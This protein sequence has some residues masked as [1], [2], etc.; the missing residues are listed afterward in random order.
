MNNIENY[1]LGDYFK[2]QIESINM[3]KDGL[4]PAKV[5]AVHKEMYIIIYD[6]IEK[7]ARLKGSTFYNDEYSVYPTVGDFVLVK[8]NPY[9][10]DIIHHVLDRK[11]K[12]SRYD[13]HYDKEQI[14]AA[15]F[16]RVFIVSSL[17]YDFN[18]KRIERYLAIAWESGASPAIILTKSDLVDDIRE[19]NTKIEEVAIGVPIFYISSLTGE[20]IDELKN[21]LKPKETIVFLGS[22]GVGKS[23]L[24]NALTG[25]EVMKVNDIREDD[26]KGR[27]TTTHRQLIMLSN[28]TMV[29]DTPGMREIALW[30][31]EDG[32]SNTFSD[33]EELAS[34]CK[35]NDCTHKK[36]PG[37]AIKLALLK[38]QLSKDRWNNYLKLQ[39]E[40][41]FTAKKERINLM[42]K[43]KSK[44]K[45]KA[46]LQNE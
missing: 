28:G 9:G 7:R 26:S 17:N 13:S 37:C 19:Y 15:N 23:S 35:F 16:D 41:K 18:I 46:K 30:N 2:G 10:E 11:S 21:Y 12:F 31:V 42:K 40:V 38:N 24:V 5:A 44:G 27:H 43:E 34:Q 36:E 1:G 45:V 33:I 22:S 39:R 6:S 20:G 29:I 8:P 32:L 3:E 14:I 4:M 25:E